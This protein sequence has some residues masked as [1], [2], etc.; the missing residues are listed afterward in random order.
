M[1]NK[2]KKV[3]LGIDPGT[4]ILGYGVVSKENKDIKSIK[5]DILSLKKHNSHMAKLKKIFYNTIDLIVQY[6]PSEIAIEEQFY[7]KNVQSMLKLSRAQGVVIAAAL[8]KEIAVQAYSPRK[9]KQSITG[10]GNASKEQVAYM[11]FCFSFSVQ[12]TIEIYLVLSGGPGFF[13][14]YL[15]RWNKSF[16]RNY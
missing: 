12:I 11:I 7:G 1:V 14:R 4:S 16:T 13:Y 3:I 2:N 15:Y 6:N 9:I 10:N 5:Y 8:S